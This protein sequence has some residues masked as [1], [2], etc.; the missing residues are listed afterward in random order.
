MLVYAKLICS[1]NN[2]VRKMEY[3]SFDSRGNGEHNS[4]GFLEI[5]KIVA[6]R[7]NTFN[8]TVPSDRL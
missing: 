7:D 3:D 6:T 2:G 5:S 1:L 4:V 8:G